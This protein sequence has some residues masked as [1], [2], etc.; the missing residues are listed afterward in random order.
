MKYLDKKFSVMGPG[1][2][3]YLDNW[4]RIFGC[5]HLKR[6]RDREADAWRCEECLEFVDPPEAEP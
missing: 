4:D 2:Q 6:W 3:E 1:T 5:K